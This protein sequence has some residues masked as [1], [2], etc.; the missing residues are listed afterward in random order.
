MRFRRPH[1]PAPGAVLLLTVAS[2]LGANLASAAESPGPPCKPCFGLALADPA[3]VSAATAALPIVPALEKDARLYFAW[4]VDLDGES[5]ASTADA[6]RALA[7]AGGVPWMRLEFG[8]SSPLIE[9]VAAL[10]V[11]LESAA[12]LARAAPANSHFEVAWR[13]AAAASAPGAPPSAKEYAFLFKRAAV[14]LGGA[15]PEARILTEPLAADAAWFEA[16]YAEE[17]AAY[18][19]GVVLRSVPEAEIAA[20]AAKLAELDPGRPLAV[21]AAPWPGDSRLALAEAARHAAAG[22]AVTLFEAPAE[23][24]AAT[25]APLKIGANE[26]RGDLS[27]DPYSRPEGAAG[28][29]SFVRGE[30]LSLRV[31]ATPD[32]PAAELKLSFPDPQLRSPAAVN[33]FT[34]ELI[35]LGGTRAPNEPLRLSLRKTGPVV[36]L[37]VERVAAEELDGGVAEKV[38]VAGAREIPVEEILRRLQEFEDAQSRRLR[39]YQAVNITKLRFQA[40]SGVQT[41][42]TSF[43]GAYFF[44]QGEPADWAWQKFYINGL[45]WRSD[46]I[47]EIPLI[48]PEKAA[49]MPLEILFTK[50]YRYALRGTD[51][52]NGRDC[53]VVDFEPAVPVEQKSLYRGTVWVDRELGARVRSRAY[54]LGLQGEVLS[55]EETI[56]Y[57]PIDAAGAPAPWAAGSYFLP[58][59]VVAQQILSIVNTATVV[60]K[61]VAL[62]AVVV[63]GESFDAARAEL[64]AS[65]A[66]VLRDTAAGLR[67]L[68]KDEATGERVVKEGF[69]TS[70]LFALGGVFYDDSLDYPLPLAGVDYFDLN[71]RGTDKQLN[72]F[73]AGVLGIANFADPRLGDS[74]FDVGADL[75]VLAI[76]TSDQLYRDG[77][78]ATAEE[79]EDRN[80][81]ITLNLGH[82]LGNYG[83]ATA[84]YQLAYTHYGRADDAADEFVVPQST[85]THRLGLE[86][87]FARSGYRIAASGFVHERQDWEFWG[88]PGNLEF[89][90]AQEKFTTWNLAV[91]KNWYFE[92]F[93]KLGLELNYAGGTDLD[94]FSKYQFGFFGGNRV[95]GY[96][97]GKVRAEEVYAGHLSYGFE[98]GSLFRLEGLLDAAWATDETS[99]LD[100]ELLAGAGVSGTFVGPWETLINI[101][102][103]AP[104]DGPDDGM[105]AYVVFLKLFD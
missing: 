54:Q 31:L 60:E 59:R 24:A 87:A 47:P 78:E 97:M 91:S 96:Q 12:A 9:N 75:F 14:A 56:D 92:N 36:L 51:T 43:E 81:Q 48:Q 21:D 44:R 68:V 49:S 62:S 16:W 73:F 39:H 76:D 17:V 3:A 6:A 19:D 5:L 34:G 10:Q 40:A 104:V 85:L 69:D 26:F 38:E 25:L 37:R 11:E 41:L 71:F 29:W 46:D 50:E 7:A 57:S 2:L 27:L 67:Y 84:S 35:P 82:P 83:K 33:L 45:E 20:L 53:W 98:I 88:L 94:R 70:K 99:G 77:I 74:R 89:D 32:D 52:V 28:A 65:E 1:A 8:T 79:V 86:L 23:I 58:L 93:R 30:D 4:N 103:G 66:T 105:V 42:E 22:V 101:D 13:P 15:S 95:H 63:N 55:N 100:N 80:S 72:A 64:L 102:I 18:V 90:P 61:E